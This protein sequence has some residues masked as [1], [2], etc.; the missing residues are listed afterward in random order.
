MNEITTKEVKFVND[1][2]SLSALEKIREIS[3]KAKEKKARKSPD[4]VNH[5]HVNEDLMIDKSKENLNFDRRKSHFPT[6][7]FSGFSLLKPK[8]DDLKNEGIRKSYKVRGEK[9]ETKDYKSEFV[10]DRRASKLVEK[11]IPLKGL[12]KIEEIEEKNEPKIKKEI[13]VSNPNPKRS[14]KGEILQ[15]L[16]DYKKGKENDLGKKTDYS[17][18][19]KVVKE[20]VIEDDDKN[21]V[22]SKNTKIFKKVVKDDKGERIIIK[23]VVEE[24]SEGNK[25]DKLVFGEDSDGEDFENELKDIDNNSPDNKD[26]KYQIVKERYDPKGNKI[27]TKEIMTNKLP[28]EY[29]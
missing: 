5:I 18:S 11:K 9:P 26:T 6:M 12:D 27:Y 19:K 14:E 23:K 1:P 17:Y 10:W 3:N 20:G 24:I 28:K 4:R 25:D 15:K 21:I 22:G 29:K 13:K 8:E 2:K 16:K 7:A